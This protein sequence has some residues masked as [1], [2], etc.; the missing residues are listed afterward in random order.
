MDD[1]ID[2]IRLD[3]WILTHHSEKELKELFL[4]MDIALKY[5]HEHDYCIEEFYPT[6]IEVL[7]HSLQQIRFKKLIQLP[8][9]SFLK[10]QYVSEDIFNSALI[11]IGI[12]SGT[13][14][15]LTPE[16]LK[17]NF[18]SFSEFI[19]NDLNPYYRGVIQRGANIY[20]CDYSSERIKRDM[21]QLEQELSGSGENMGK[22]L[23]K[24]S[25]HNL[26]VGPISNDKINDQI[27]RQINGMKDSAF[28]RILVIPT[29]I[30]ASL[31]FI[32]IISFIISY[33]R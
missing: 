20:L 27:Y 21:D 17:E 4:N 28:V 12:Y 30:L 32:S 8:K 2:S 29:M 31:L 5:I 19:P 3:E 26:G 1:R 9:D 7:N 11:Q 24:D 14:E 16:F 25:G 33:F 13:L 18:D 10:N 15:Y 22:Q 23:V 6:K